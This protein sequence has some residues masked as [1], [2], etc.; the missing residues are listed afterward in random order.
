MKINQKRYLQIWNGLNN[1]FEDI[2]FDLFSYYR[3]AAA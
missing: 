3:H 1:I 2:S